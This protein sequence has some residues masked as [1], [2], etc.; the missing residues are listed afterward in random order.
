[1]QPTKSSFMKVSFGQN[2][3]RYQYML[4]QLSVEVKARICSTLNFNQEQMKSTD[5]TFSGSSW[6][7]ALTAHPL[8]ISIIW[9]VPV[10]GIT[11]PDREGKVG[12]LWV[13]RRLASP[14]GL[15]FTSFT[16]S[17]LVI[18]GGFGPTFSVAVSYYTHSFPACVGTTSVIAYLGS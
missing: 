11:P 18:L 6:Q 17:S 7:A 10:R 2:L 13:E 5:D 12:D 15:V 1:M 14:H 4:K 9:S 8:P 16:G 3:T